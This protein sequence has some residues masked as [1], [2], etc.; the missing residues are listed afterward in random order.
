M[1]FPKLIFIIPYRDRE[2]EKVIFLDKMRIL[3]DHVD[4]NDYKIYFVNQCDDQ[5]FNRGAIKNIGFLMVKNKYPTCYKNITLCFNDVDT[6]PKEKGLIDNYITIPGIVK[7]FYGY[8]FALG[9]I[10][11]ITCHDFEITN[12]FGNYF[13]WGYEDNIL[14]ERVLK[15]NMI[16][17]RSVF[18]NIDDKQII[19][20]KSSPMRVVNSNDFRRYLQQVPEGIN[21]ISNL[22]YHIDEENFLVNVKNFETGYIHKKEYDSN[23]NSM[24]KKPPFVHG[25]SGSKRLSMNFVFS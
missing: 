15:A 20:L 2:K 13:S 3:L 19:Q 9:G 14:N 7:H 22:S 1:I 10:V 21:S 5:P 17:D 25:R 24:S 11:S 6:F 18:F 8:K 4:V 16:I 12:G 23:Y